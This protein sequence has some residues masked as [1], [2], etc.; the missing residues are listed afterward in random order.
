[1]SMLPDVSGTEDGRGKGE[2]RKADSAGMMPW[3]QFEEGC[4]CHSA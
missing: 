3:A 2:R 1:M 4:D